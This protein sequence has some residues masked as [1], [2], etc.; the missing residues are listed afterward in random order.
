[1]R[2]LHQEESHEFSR[3]SDFPGKRDLKQGYNI[4]LLKNVTGGNEKNVRG[5]AKRKLGNLVPVERTVRSCD[6]GLRSRD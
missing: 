2:D 6:D 4:V 3:E 1:M 5:K